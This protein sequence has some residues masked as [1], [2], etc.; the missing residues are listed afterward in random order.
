MTSP[1]H[2]SLRLMQASNYEDS[3]TSLTKRSIHQQTIR[4][5]SVCGLAKLEKHMNACDNTSYITD[6]FCQE[7][8]FSTCSYPPPSNVQVVFSH[9]GHHEMVCA[10]SVST[11]QSGNFR[12]TSTTRPGHSLFYF[13]FSSTPTASIAALYQPISTHFL[14]YP[15][16][17]STLNIYRQNHHSQTD[18]DILLS[19][20]PPG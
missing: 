18:S 13:S 12:R 14:Q 1:R 9:S 19:P 3:F 8:K 7:G 17:L 2:Q 5:T 6:K 4:Q 11:A 10:T 16:D 15:G 20:L